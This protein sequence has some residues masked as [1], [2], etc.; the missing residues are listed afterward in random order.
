[1]AATSSSTRKMADQQARHTGV[2]FLIPTLHGGG[3]ERVVTTL[4][5]HLDRSRFKPTLAVVDTRQAVYLKEI[6]EERRVHRPGLPARALRPAENSCAD[7]EAA[8]GHS[9]LDIGPFEP[10]LGHAPAIAAAPPAL[11]C[12]GNDRRQSG[13]GHLRESL[14]LAMDV[15]AIS[16]QS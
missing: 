11:Y 16:R 13:P 2:L 1:M 5:R 15:P 14:A 6:P 7:L 8:A 12:P 10:G 4:L 9:L 3:A